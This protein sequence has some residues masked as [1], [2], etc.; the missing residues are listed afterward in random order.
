MKSKCA[1]WLQ[2]HKA[3]DVSSRLI[4]RITDPS[5]KLYYFKFTPAKY[6]IHRLHLIVD[7][8]DLPSSSIESYDGIKDKALG[9]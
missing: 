6:T 8:E 7:E 9:E 2:P 4:E 1:I 5:Y 3:G